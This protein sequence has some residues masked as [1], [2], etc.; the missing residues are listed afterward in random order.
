MFGA[1]SIYGG[2]ESEADKYGWSESGANIDGHRV[3]QIWMV[4]EWGKY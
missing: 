1:W 4:G 2:S 3:V